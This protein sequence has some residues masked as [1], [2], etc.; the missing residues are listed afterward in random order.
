VFIPK[1][2]LAVSGEM[3]S[4]DRTR[5]EELNLVRL[6]DAL[7]CANCE[8]IVSECVNGG[9][10]ACGSHAMLSVSKALGG[11]LAGSQNDQHLPPLQ[12][13]YSAGWEN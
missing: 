8:L 9:C 13:S 5:L 12:T 1:K 4:M 2:R 10:P 7:L 11:T 3:K 6:A